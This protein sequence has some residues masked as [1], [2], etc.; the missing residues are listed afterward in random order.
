M[1]NRMMWAGWIR[2]DYQRQIRPMLQ[3]LFEHPEETREFLLGIHT[4]LCMFDKAHAEDIRTSRLN[5]GHYRRVQELVATVR[6]KFLELPFEK[7]DDLLPQFCRP[8]E[9]GEGF[10]MAFLLFGTPKRMREQA[11]ARF[12]CL[13]D[14]CRSKVGSAEWERNSAAWIL[15]LVCILTAS[16]TNGTA[17]WE[18]TLRY[19]H[20]TGDYSVLCRFIECFAAIRPTRFVP[21]AFRSWCIG[22]EVLLVDEVA[23]NTLNLP[24]PDELIEWFSDALD[25]AYRRIHE[26]NQGIFHLVEVVQ[27]NFGA[28]ARA[29]ED[30]WL[31]IMVNPRHALRPDGRDRV[32]VTLPEF[33]QFGHREIVLYPRENFP[34]FRVRYIRHAHGTTHALEM[35]LTP[36]D[37]SRVNVGGLAESDV[38]VG[39]DRILAFIAL[40]CAWRIVMGA[41]ACTGEGRP[42][43]GGGSGAAVVRPYV[44]HLPEGQRISV[45]ARARA[46]ATF[47]TAPLPGF[48]F[49]RGYT[50]GEPDAET[51]EPLFSVTADDFS[52]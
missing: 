38:A 1:H 12:T 52:V 36:T 29:Y 39:V 19:M 4:I 48:T 11:V 31:D 26:Q 44:R 23:G 35:A 6:Q 33:V 5:R 16:G 10:A 20:Q 43:N 22:D 50:R 15:I 18:E 34:D 49:V 32:R 41:T 7:A 46:L 3:N 42:A 14:H 21:K 27:R 8:E 37:L 25:E 9:S 51:G 24:V 2:A 13:V 47:Q 30:M 40:R 17:T 45:E 28:Y